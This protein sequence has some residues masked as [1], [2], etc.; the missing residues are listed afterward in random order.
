MKKFLF[1]VFLV[2]IITIQSKGNNTN[3][4]KT[5]ENHNQKINNEEEKKQHLNL[6]LNNIQQTQEKNNSKIKDINNTNIN[7]N[8]TIN[9][10][11]SINNNTIINNNSINDKTNKKCRRNGTVELPKNIKDRLDSFPNNGMHFATAD[12]LNLTEALLNFYNQNF[13]NNSQQNSNISKEVVEN[14]KKFK[15]RMD[16][17]MNEQAHGNRDNAENRQ[18]AEMIKIEK[19]KID[20]QKKEEKREKDQFDQDMI[21]TVFTD[22]FLVIL[23]RGEKEKFYLDLENNTK[24]I[25]AFFVSDEEEKIKFTFNGPDTRGKNIALFKISKRNYFYFQFETERKGEYSVELLNSG[26]KQNEIDFFVNENVNKTKDSINTEKIDKISLL[27]D[28]IKK[29]VNK[30]K[31]RKKNEINMLNAHNEKVNKN[32]RSIVVYSIIEIFT[33]IIILTFQSYYIR[34]F[35]KKV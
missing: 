26:S 30:L 20:I 16:K 24:I 19:E 8:S 13:G 22:S 18:K 27:L 31:K 11:T 7:N 14:M 23:E 10:N 21:N 1:L 25:I 17:G 32:N 33:M 35:A 6:N 29:N 12:P 28:G 4:N 34:S 9:N 2:P 3:I 15:E 5:Q